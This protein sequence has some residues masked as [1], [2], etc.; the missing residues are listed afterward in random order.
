MCLPRKLIISSDSVI[1]CNRLQF[2]IRL[3]YAMT[4]N[5]LQGQTV[6]VCGLNLENPCLCH[7]QLYNARSSVRKHKKMI[8]T[9]KAKIILCSMT[10][11]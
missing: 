7:G 2:P 11:I 5:K 8:Y 3:A 4:I 10:L 6:T 1:P 9:P